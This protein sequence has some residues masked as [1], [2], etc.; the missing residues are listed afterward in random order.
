MFGQ[1]TVSKIK[2]TSKT[3]IIAIKIKNNGLDFFEMSNLVRNCSQVPEKQK[4]KIKFH[5]RIEFDL[6]MSNAHCRLMK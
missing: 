1:N 2:T 3:N 6:L 5:Q 4:Q